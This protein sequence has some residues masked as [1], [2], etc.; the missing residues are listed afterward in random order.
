MAAAVAGIQVRGSPSW[1][2]RLRMSSAQDVRVVETSREQEEER[3]EREGQED[4]ESPCGAFHVHRAGVLRPSGAA[5]RNSTA[6][7][8]QVSSRT[9]ALRSRRSLG[10]APRRLS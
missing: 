2:G 10:T 8:S 5:A 3:F 9:Q 4:E 1:C 6:S 7:T